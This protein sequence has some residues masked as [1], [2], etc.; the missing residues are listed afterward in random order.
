[1]FG[2][3]PATSRRGETWRLTLVGALGAA[4]YLLI[5][6]TIAEP[7]SNV[8]RWWVWCDPV[9]GCLAVGAVLWR[10]RFPMPIA[11]ATVLASVV[12]ISSAPAAA[13]A[14]ASVATRRRWI[15]LA[16]LMPCWALGAATSNWFSPD[17]DSGIVAGLVLQ[18]AVFGAF[19]GIG[20]AIG[21]R[22]D[23]VTALRQR[24]ETVEREQ[25]SR[26]ARAQASERARIAREMH[27]VLAH[28]ISLIALHA[29]AL[30]YRQDL[31]E[32]RVHQTAE[33]LRDNADRAVGELR[34]VL[35]VLRDG[36]DIDPPHAPTPDLRSLPELLAD[37][38]TGQAEAALDVRL[39]GPATLADVPATPSR[40]AYRVVQEALT[41]ARK[42][43]PGM[44]VSVE[45]E[46]GPGP[47]LSFLIRNPPLSY[48]AAGVTSEVSGMGLV[49]LTERV[50][51]GGGV[52]A[53]GTEPTGDFVVHGTLPWSDGNAT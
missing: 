18:L 12:S 26:I 21:S 17:G 6:V 10:R 36:E 39:S 25:A 2:A 4:I 51:L 32:E 46:G 52:L 8:P 15:E 5:V 35:G 19:A 20:A 14:L 27:D 24:A 44:P 3:I 50:T 48:G 7:G 1:M 47:G 11:V 23:T 28:R 45:L 16:V 9:L 34:E 53:Y 49:G 37:S 33:L 30:A 38:N 13:L 40:T 43:A 29:G 22:R 31:T 42:H 41:N